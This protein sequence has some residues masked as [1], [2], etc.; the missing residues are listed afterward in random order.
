MDDSKT[1][2]Y[3]ENQSFKAQRPPSPV[4]EKERKLDISKLC[5]IIAVESTGES[6][7]HDVPKQREKRL[8]FDSQ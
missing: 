2:M 1:S 5:N 8:L 7:E 6:A 4:Q 3:I